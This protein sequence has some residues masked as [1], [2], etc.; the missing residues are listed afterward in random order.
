MNRSEINEVY[1]ANR[2]KDFKRQAASYDICRKWMRQLEKSNPWL[3]GDQV[4][5]TGYQHG[6]AQAEIWRQY[7]YLRRQMAKVDQLLDRIEEKHGLIAR[8]IVYLQYVEKEKQKV[9]SEEY[10]I[11]LRT[12]QRSIHT[13]M[14]DALAYEAK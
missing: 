9:L 11:C 5:D 1:V 12:M 13:W 2:V 4:K 8:Q 6:K 14:E 10:G 7:M 3:C